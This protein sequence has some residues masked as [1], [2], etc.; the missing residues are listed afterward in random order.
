MADA[1][2]YRRQV[3]F[4]VHS[5]AATNLGIT[6]C[7]TPGFLPCERGDMNLTATS[8]VR[9]ADLASPARERPFGVKRPMRPRSPDSSFEPNGHLSGSAVL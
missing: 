4:E 8:A 3:A 5:R 2:Y 9:L 7:S 6:S 1:N